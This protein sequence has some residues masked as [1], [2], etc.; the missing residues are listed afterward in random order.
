MYSVYL[1]GE[2]AL[3]D[4]DSV[5]ITLIIYRTGYIRS[6]KLVL[7]TGPYAEWDKKKRCFTPTSPDNIAKNKL[8]QHERTKYLKIAERWEYSGK[9][10]E[11]TELAHY[12]DTSPDTRK[13]SVFVVDVFDRMIE[14]AK[15]SRR[16]RN[17]KEF[18]GAG[19]ARHIHCTRQALERFVHAKY[20]RKF[21]RYRFRDIDGQFLTDFHLYERKR[22]AKG[23][24]SGGADRKIK[25]LYSICRKAKSLGI[26]G[27]D[28]VEFKAVKQSLRQLQHFS[29]AVSHETILAIEN[30]DRSTLDKR[31][32][33]ELWL[34]LF[35]FS[36]YTAGMSGI[37]ICHMERSWIKGDTIEYE[38]TKY[39]NKAR[40][41]L[42]DKAAGLI[43]KYRDEAYMNYV[44]PIFKKRN[45]SPPSRMNSVGYVNK[46]VN[47][48]LKKVCGQI[49]ITQK[50]T[51]STARSS[52]I[53]KMVDEGCPVLQICE[54]TGNSPATI[55][56]YYYTITNTTA[57]RH[58]MNKIF[59]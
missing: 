56:K 22:G 35:L 44:F 4:A 31:K 5:K 13:R 25:I 24:T 7:I 42:T 49:G 34:D 16:I 52:S 46:R 41:I 6:E 50:I 3:M 23:N 20:G 58:K 36:Y 33:E 19:L 55:H 2:R 12:Y 8:L 32:R 28:L 9:N 17:G 11:P 51:W 43:E 53:S 47:A 38:R 59:T 40:V 57:M 10:W 14:E 48:T 27:V 45:M 39:P 54:Q 1:R 37:D 15:T 21:S 18:S 30:V 26:Y 29:K